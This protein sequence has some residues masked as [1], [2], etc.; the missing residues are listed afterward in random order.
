[1]KIKALE[2]AIERMMA[3]GEP[4]NHTIPMTK[5]QVHC[6]KDQLDHRDD[7]WYLKGTTHRII[8]IPDCIEEPFLTAEERKYLEDITIRDDVRYQK[9]MELYGGIDW[10]VGDGSK[11]NMETPT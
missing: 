2:D 10:G 9:Y 1:M 6:C 5:K 7:A 11:S 4:V 8:I 3:A